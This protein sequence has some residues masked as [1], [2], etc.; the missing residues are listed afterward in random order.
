MEGKLT[1]LGPGCSIEENIRGF[2][3]N[4]TNTV[5]HVTRQTMYKKS[6]ITT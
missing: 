3:H 5:Q 4:I 2:V 6:S 1:L